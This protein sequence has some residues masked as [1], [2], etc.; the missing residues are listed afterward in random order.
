MKVNESSSLMD[1]FTFWNVLLFLNAVIG[2]L[3][4][5]WSFYKFRRF[6]NPNKDLDALYPAF[7]RND[8]QHWSK[9]K[10]YSGAMTIL[11]P[12]AFL[13]GSFLVT[14]AFCSKVLRVGTQNG[15]PI[16]GLRKTFLMVCYKVTAFSIAMVGFFTW[17]RWERVSI[18]GNYQEYLGT[19][20]E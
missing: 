6:R 1:Y 9:W 19:V 18:K 5:E 4:L 20:E 7:R 12:R 17:L 15:A 14:L 16:E 11:L 10:L 13:L 3:V 8:A 2:L